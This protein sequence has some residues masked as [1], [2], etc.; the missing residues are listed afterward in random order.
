MKKLIPLIVFLL[1][2]PVHFE[3]GGAVIDKITIVGH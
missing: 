2:T 1:A 3:Y